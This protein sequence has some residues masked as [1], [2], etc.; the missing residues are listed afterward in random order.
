MD[1]CLKITGAIAPTAD[2]NTLRA[3]HCVHWSDMPAG[4]RDQ[5]LVKTLEL[6]TNS[7]F[8]LD[9]IMLSAAAGTV[10]ALQ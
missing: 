6:F 8:S 3:L 2:Y 10:R 1:S 5:V 9:Q 7:G 4:F